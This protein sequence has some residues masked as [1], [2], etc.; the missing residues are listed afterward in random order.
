[1]IS[2]LG[3]AAMHSG[4]QTRGLPGLPR[5]ALADADPRRGAASGRL[6]HPARLDRRAREHAQ[7]LGRAVWPLEALRGV[8]ETAR[9][10]GLAVHLD[11]ARL[12]NAAVALGRAGRGDRRACSTR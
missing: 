12:A 11:G 8:V 9:E 4:L 3:G 1:M 6:P 5:R 7:Q 10:L 2:E